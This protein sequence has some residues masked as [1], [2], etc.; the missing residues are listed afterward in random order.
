MTKSKI[1][2]FPQE[3]VKDH[4]RF[5]YQKENWIQ[6]KHLKDHIYIDLEGFYLSFREQVTQLLIDKKIIRYPTK[7]EELHLDLAS[8]WK[9]YGNDGISK[10]A[11][12]FY[13]YL[14]NTPL[15]RNLHFE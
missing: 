5:A 4:Y 3:Y 13:D 7:L 1:F 8:E 12:L 6:Q 14:S 15:V 11:T 9:T 2:S 10:I